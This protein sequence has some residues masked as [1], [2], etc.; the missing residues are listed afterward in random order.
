[1]KSSYDFV[2]VGAGVFGAWTAWHLR[3]NGAAVA[4]VDAYGPGNSR[5][6]SGGE[7]RL[8]RM[9]YGPDELYTQMALRSL[10]QWMELGKRTGVSLF[11][12]TGVLWLSDRTDPYVQ[13]LDQTLRRNGVPTELMV[14]PELRR[15]WPQ[16]LLADD[17]A[18]VFEPASGA[19]MARRAVQSL[20]SE[21]AVG[22]VDYGLA[23][24]VPPGGGKTLDA[25]QLTSGERMSAGTFV[26]ACGSWLP[27][28]FPGLL[29]GIIQPTRQEVFFLG[30]PAGNSHFQVGEM[31]AWLH[32]NHPDRPYLLPDIE[33]R[34]LK[35]AFDFHGPQAD[36]DTEARVVG[37]DSLDHMRSYVEEHIPELRNAP[38]LETRVCQYE[39]TSNGD[40]LI[41]RHPEWT[42]VWI[43]GGGSGHGFK[44][45]P[46]VGEYLS[47]QILH[48][49]SPEPRF[50]LSRKSAARK[51]EVF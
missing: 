10:P 27:K 3:R 5:S 33:N 8:I 19:L 51:R 37:R 25:I 17:M 34:G 20:V 48:Q 28:L 35:I 1:M 12:Q 21:M 29:T 9:G 45:G 46:A 44:H 47:E 36:P 11:H 49:A 38:I 14:G 39:N 13:Q 22:G 31:P 6:S 43:A 23:A 16:L 24:V 30:V 4:L 41:D 18:G 2:V 42:N 26:F 40:F 32:H 50:A 7:T 15:R